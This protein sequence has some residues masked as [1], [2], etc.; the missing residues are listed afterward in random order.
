MMQNRVTEL[1]KSMLLAEIN[2]SNV[3]L[4]FLRNKEVHKVAVCGYRECGK[5]VVSRLEESGFIVPYI[6]E[7]NYESLRKVESIRIP[8]V[9]FQEEELYNQAQV[10]L[11]TPDMDR[12]IVRECLELAGITIKQMILDELMMEK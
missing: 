10:L 11:L 3:W 8:I 12:D 2:E 1:E 9:G 4:E 7:R 5:A 6:V